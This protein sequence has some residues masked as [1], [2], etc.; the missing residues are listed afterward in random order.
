MSEIDILVMMFFIHFVFDYYI[1]SRSNVNIKSINWWLKRHPRN[2]TKAK[3][4]CYCGLM[5]HSFTWSYAVL[6]PFL[7]YTWSNNLNNAVLYYFM[8]T[9]ALVHCVIDDMKTN[10]RCIN[11]ITD[12]FLHSIQIVTL[13]LVCYAIYMM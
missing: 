2:I 13:W 12:Q 7:Y 9:N 1:Q 5:M 11:S 3:M 4:C 8:F 6:L 10:S